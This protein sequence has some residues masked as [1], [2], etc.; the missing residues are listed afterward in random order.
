MI[1]VMA[2]TADG[3][4]IAERLYLKGAKVLVTVTTNYGAS[5]FGD[6][7]EVWRGPL[8]KYALV[9]LMRD[10]GIKVVIDATHPFAA[11]ASINAIKAS[12]EAGIRY[13]RYERKG[14]S[15]NGA[16]W[17]KDFNEAANECQKYDNIF[18]AIGSKNLERFKPLWESGKRVTVRVLPSS[19]IVKKCEDLG[20]IP[21]RIIAMMGPFSIGL[22]YQLFKQATAQAIVTKDSGIPGGVPEKVKAAEMLG[23]PAIV[24]KRPSVNYPFVIS[25]I[26]TLIDE[27]TIK[28][29]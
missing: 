12:K 23:I 6:E 18:L 7:I 9:E 3:R 28:W 5:F 15:C 21:D 19:H 27:V 10:K 14:T 24:V 20:L 8:N 16:V 26:D 11:N 17:V 29:I 22:N 13:I 25:N 2:G 1:L 4:E